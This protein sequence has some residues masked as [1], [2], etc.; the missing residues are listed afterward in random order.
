MHFEEKRERER[1][2][3]REEV[4]QAGRECVHVSVLFGRNN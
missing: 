2:R 3:E 1:E 4:E